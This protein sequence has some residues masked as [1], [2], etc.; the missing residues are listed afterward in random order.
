MSD[1]NV[2]TWVCWCKNPWYRCGLL[3]SSSLLW[4]DW[5]I[6]PDLLTPSVSFVVSC[7]ELVNVSPLPLSFFRI[8]SEF[9]LLPLSTSYLHVMPE[10]DIW[11][12]SPLTSH[13][14]STCF[15]LDFYPQSTKGR[16]WLDEMCPGLWFT[17]LL[18]SWLSDRLCSRVFIFSH[19]WSIR[20]RS[21]VSRYLIPPVSDFLPDFPI[22]CAL[23]CSSFRTLHS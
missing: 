12:A 20:I 21:N 5:K 6:A 13:P 23:E 10:R 4:C 8:P 19:N 16:S 7:S 3:I 1:P 22:V 2:N 17:Q 11:Y 14:H 18:A 15:L 9:F